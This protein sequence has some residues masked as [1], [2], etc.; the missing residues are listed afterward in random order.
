MHVCM[1]VSMYGWTHTC[2]HPCIQHPQ[3]HSRVLPTYLQ[4]TSYTVRLFMSMPIY[5]SSYPSCEHFFSFMSSYNWCLFSLGYRY[6]TFRIIRYFHWLYCL[7]VCIPKLAFL[8]IV[9]Y[10][11][12]YITHVNLWVDTWLD[13]TLCIYN[14]AQHLFEN[15]R[16]ISSIILI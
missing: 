11:H 15:P 1:Y 2:I 7:C 8:V 9:C 3:T 13:T 10:G 4:P 14:I 5:L 12:A 16:S 6:I